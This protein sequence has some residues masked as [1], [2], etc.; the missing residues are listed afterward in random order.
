[1]ATTLAAKTETPAE[2]EAPAT[3]ETLATAKLTTA[4]KTAGTL[5]TLTQHSDVKT[6][7]LKVVF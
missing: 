6:I 5:V 1:M 4:S 3:A 7:F 2:V